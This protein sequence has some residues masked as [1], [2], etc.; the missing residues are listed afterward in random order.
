L[1]RAD[2]AVTPPRQGFDKARILSRV[3]E[4]ATELSDGAVEPGIEIDERLSTP[5]PLPKPAD[6]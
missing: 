3:V 5:Q 6:A 2:T 1:D 4:R